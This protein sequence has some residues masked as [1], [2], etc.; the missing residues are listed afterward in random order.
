M[1]DEEV[2]G[3][4]IKVRAKFTNP[5]GIGITP[6]ESRIS[7]KAPTGDITTVSG[8]LLIPHTTISGMFYFVY[9]P[10]VIGW[11]EYESWG[12][13]GNDNERVE[14]SGFEITDR[15]YPDP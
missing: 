11:Y 10:P 5:E 15:L 1:T 13:D 9:R 6:I 3:G 2:L 12:K 8:D 4:T 7:V 14:T